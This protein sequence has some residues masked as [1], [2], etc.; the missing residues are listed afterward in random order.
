MR[1]LVILLLWLSLLMGFP[2]SLLANDIFSIL[3]GVA[4]GLPVVHA[5]VALIDGIAGTSLEDKLD[6]INQRQQTSLDRIRKVAYNALETKQRIEDIYYFTKWGIEEAQ[7]LAEELKKGNIGKIIGSL[8]EDGL[9]IPINPA[10]YIPDIPEAAELRRN[11]DLD[12]SMERS[13]VHRTD[14]LLRGTRAALMR[15]GLFDRNPKRFEQEYERALAYEA[16][17]EKALRAKEIARVKFYKAE[18]ERLTKE[19]RY[20]ERIKGKKGLTVGE[21]V[22]IEQTIDDKRKELLALNV[23]IDQ[24]LAGSLA[25]TEEELFKLAVYK[26]NRDADQLSK[27]LEKDRQRMR[28][29]YAHLW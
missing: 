16:C 12:L 1:W 14:Y 5:G 6:Q 2:T 11:L 18:A 22:H 25:L 26:A 15:T 3:K 28:S 24:Q 17:L 19:L 13:I 4:S 29:K 8:L 10:E 27:E 20:L 21:V 23:Y 7:L 9:A